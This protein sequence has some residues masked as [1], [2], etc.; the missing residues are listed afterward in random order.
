MK[1]KIK[2]VKKAKEIFK[3]DFWKIILAYILFF[4]FLTLNDF[5]YWCFFIKSSE[6]CPENAWQIQLLTFFT[7]LLS[8]W[9]IFTR[10]LRDLTFEKNFTDVCMILF[11]VAISYL[12]SCSLIFAKKKLKKKVK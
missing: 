2:L 8:P 6:Y 1:I 11:F 9:S 3:P 4:G 5:V 7:N 12:I 10:I